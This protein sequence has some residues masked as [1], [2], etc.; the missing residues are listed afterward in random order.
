M[1]SATLTGTLTLTA[2]SVGT[3]TIHVYAADGQHFDGQIPVPV[4]ESFSVTV[5]NQAPMA[6]TAGLSFN[7]L[8]CVPAKWIAVI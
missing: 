8:A 6:V 2:V 4:R 3:A 1:A 7:G 5:V